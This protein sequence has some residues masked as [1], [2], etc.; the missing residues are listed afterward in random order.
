MEN[1]KDWL[2]NKRSIYAC[3][4]ASNHTQEDRQ[5]EDYYA[6]DPLAAELLLK[7]EVFNNDIWEV[8][9]GEGHLSEV[10]IKKGYNVKSS[11]IVDRGYG[12]IYDFLSIDNQEWKGDIITNPPYTYAKDFIE[13]SLQ[14]IPD[15]NK[16]A[17]FLKLTFLEGQNRKSLFTTFPPKYLYVSSS[18]IKCAKNGDFN[19]YSSSAI[20]YGWYVWYKGY[21]GDTIIKWIN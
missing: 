1:N 17:M 2:G 10:F 7:H 8:S 11:D 21:K 6:T 19:Q 16:I 3:I 14:I 5:R 4:G 18:R 15:G 12:I 13:K 20:A 9:C